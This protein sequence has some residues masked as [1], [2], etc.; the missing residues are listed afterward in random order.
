ML[1]GPYRLSFPS[2]TPQPRCL[3]YLPVV[4]MPRILLS[5]QNYIYI[6]TNIKKKKYEYYDYIKRILLYACVFDYYNYLLFHRIVNVPQFLS[7]CSTSIR[8]IIVRVTKYEPIRRHIYSGIT[9]GTKRSI[10]YGTV[11]EHIIIT[12]IAVLKT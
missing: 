6:K 8:S 4:L 7:V 1:N 11:V 10:P 5:G 12:V 2:S 3:L 9:V